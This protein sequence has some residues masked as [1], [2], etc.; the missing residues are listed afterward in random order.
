SAGRQQR[1]N[2]RELVLHWN[3]GPHRVGHFKGGG[4]NF[5]VLGR[6]AGLRS[7]PSDYLGSVI[8]R[9]T[10]RTSTLLGEVVRIPTLP[11]P[12]CRAALSRH[13]RDVGHADQIARGG[14]CG[15]V[16][17]HAAAIV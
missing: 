1:E 16:V 17:G 11:V 4:R 9:A 2:Q 8:E 12:H 13:V 14:G 10:R 3:I 15:L 5:T 6:V 7:K